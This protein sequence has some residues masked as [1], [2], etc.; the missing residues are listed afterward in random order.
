MGFVRAAEGPRYL[1]VN[2]DEGEPE[3]LKIAIIS[4]AI[5]ICFLR[6]C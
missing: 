5:R 3:P 2:G 6:V 1:A 4:S